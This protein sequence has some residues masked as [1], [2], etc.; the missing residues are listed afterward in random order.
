[1]DSNM[2]CP[3]IMPTGMTTQLWFNIRQKDRSCS[4]CRIAQMRVA[5]GQWL[6]DFGSTN[7]LSQRTRILIELSAAHAPQSDGG[8]EHGK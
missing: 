3:H 2:V 8:S 5:L 1:M 7:E 4:D 6:H